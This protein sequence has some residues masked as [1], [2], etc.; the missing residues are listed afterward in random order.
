[1]TKKKDVVYQVS[2]RREKMADRRR[3]IIYY[4]FEIVKAT[5]KQKPRGKKENV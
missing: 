3:E 2:K 4:D 1:M 5:G